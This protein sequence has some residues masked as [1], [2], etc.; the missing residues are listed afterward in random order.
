M[1]PTTCGHDIHAIAA[2]VLGGLDDHEAAEVRAS[3]DTCANCRREHDE[4]VALPRLLERARNDVTPV[5]ARVRDRVLAASARR[6]ERRRWIALTVAASLA[7]GAAGVVVGRQLAPAPSATMALEAGEE[8]IAEGSAT[9]RGDNGRVVVHLVAEGLAP[10]AEPGAYE[11]W[12]YRTDGR[13]VSIG[14]LDIGDDGVVD[15]ELEAYG[16]LGDFALF[17]VTAEPDRRDPAHDGPTVLRA[18]VPRL[19]SDR[20]DDGGWDLEP[21]AS[22]GVTGWLHPAAS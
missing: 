17:W 4:I 16:S 5:P 13:I 2:L 3:V 10:L 6:R 18:N 22:S 15:V 11:A 8:F 14:Q 21:A 9:F 12:L 1:T 19:E 20:T 7:L